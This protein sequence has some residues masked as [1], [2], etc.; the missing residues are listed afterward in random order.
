MRCKRLTIKTQKNGSV[1]KERGKKNE[2]KKNCESKKNM[3]LGDLK[4]VMGN[5]NLCL[6]R[7]GRWDST[8][9]YEHKRKCSDVQKRQYDSPSELQLLDPTYLT[10][11]QNMESKTTTKEETE[12]RFEVL[13]DGWIRD[14]QLGL[15]WG[16]S[17][18][19]RL[20]FEDAE[21]YCADKGGRLPTLRELHSLVDYEKYDPSID[22][23]VF[24]DQ[25]SSW[26]WTGTP[27]A[28]GPDY[29]WI[30]NFRYGIV[31]YDH[32]GNS[33][34]VRPCRPSQ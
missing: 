7:R 15:D 1:E 32:R 28:D 30:V 11:G 21:K 4:K 34:C 12:A 16:P 19:K 18:E 20:D 5:F 31:H 33:N 13:E 23:E 10:K 3:R 6:G 26:Y 24:K 22:K 17:S 8:L 14:R 29:A 9:L 25:E 27:V 2:G